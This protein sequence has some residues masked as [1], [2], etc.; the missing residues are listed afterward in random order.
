MVHL[1]ERSYII[2]WW[3][4]LSVTSYVAFLAKKSGL[5]N[6]IRC[7]SG[8]S[9]H[10]YVAFLANAPYYCVHNFI[11]VKLNIQGIQQHTS[12]NSGQNHQWLIYMT[13]GSWKTHKFTYITA[14]NQL[15]FTYIIAGS[16]K[17]FMIKLDTSFS[18]IFPNPGND[19]AW[20]NKD[21]TS[22]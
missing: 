11:H 7:D 3:S 18:A 4:T 12:S 16:W 19:V 15:E 8:R 1:L 20:G 5:K 2:V 21:E 14:Q 10:D 9:S 13:A 6:Q 22:D 17:T